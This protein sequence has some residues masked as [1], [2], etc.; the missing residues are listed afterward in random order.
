MTA[1]NSDLS[2][3]DVCFGGVTP[4]LRVADFERSVAYYSEV[5]GFNLKWRVG[6]FGCVRRDDAEL[7]LSEGTQ[8]CSRT[9]LWLAVSDSDALH[10]ELR[11]RGA[12]IRN[13]P[14]NY[15]WGSRELHVFD[16]DGHVLRL[17]SEALPGE[18]MGAWLDE[19]GDRWLPDEEGNWIKNPSS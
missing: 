16:A 12:H 13:P 5:L 4:I 6:N 19:Q 9:W 8:G 2:S 7:M 10:A 11:A 1:P 17:G 3:R 14:T 15:P 18:P